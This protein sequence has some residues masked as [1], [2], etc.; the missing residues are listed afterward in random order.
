MSGSRAAD[1]SL[2]VVRPCA[3][4][5]QGVSREELLF[6]AEHAML[7]AAVHFDA[8]KGAR[9][10]TYA[11]FQVMRALT[12]LVQQVRPS[13][14]MRRVCRWAIFAA[15]STLCRLGLVVPLRAAPS[16]WSSA[17]VLRRRACLSW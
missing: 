1:G 12:E 9:L 14:C 11:W 3:V 7:H 4:A 10:N 15:G 6:E 16:L 17:T 5:Q 8:A 13:L 2:S